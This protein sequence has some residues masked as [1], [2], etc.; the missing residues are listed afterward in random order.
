M[1]AAIVKAPPRALAP[2]KSTD[3]A[4]AQVAAARERLLERLEVVEKAIEPLGNW[5]A[6]V[7]RHP[8]LTIGGAFA[9]GYALSRLFS[10]R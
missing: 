10:R 3:E 8:L 9:V 2:V 7:R 6:V 1:S 4:R 5:R